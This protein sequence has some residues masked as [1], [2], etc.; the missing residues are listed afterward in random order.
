MDGGCLG[1]SRGVSKAVE[2]TIN[3]RIKLIRRVDA[4][5]VYPAQS[6]LGSPRRLKFAEALWTLDVQLPNV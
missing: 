4:A 3:E 2:T 5:T 6:S 1:R